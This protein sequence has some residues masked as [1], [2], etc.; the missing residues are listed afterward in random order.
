MT[1]TDKGG[2]ARARFFRHLVEDYSHRQAVIAQHLD[3]L[4]DLQH[5]AAV[6]GK[7]QRF[8]PRLGA[9]GRG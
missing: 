7:D 1:V 3:A 8:L 2:G 4:P 6:G 9:G 5:H